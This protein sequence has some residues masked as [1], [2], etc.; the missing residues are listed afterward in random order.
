MHVTH[1]A[2]LTLHTGPVNREDNAP[3]RYLVLVMVADLFEEKQRA[4]IPHY[5]KERTRAIA[6]IKSEANSS[7]PKKRRNHVPNRDICP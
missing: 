6:K 1:V 7:R 5:R 2:P 4:A 3:E